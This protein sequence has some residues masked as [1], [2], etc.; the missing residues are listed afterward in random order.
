VDIDIAADARDVWRLVSDI[1]LPARFSS[2]FTGAEWIEGEASE[3]A[4]F[5]GRN[6]HKAIGEWHT[7]CT[8]IACEPERVFA[9]EVQGPD[10]PS[11]EWRFEIE[12]TDDG[13]RLSQWARM[14]PGPSGLTPAILQMPDK[15]E[16]IVER[17]LEEWRTNMTSNLEGIKTLAE[18]K[19][20]T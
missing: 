9:W 4:K 7:E 12:R 17:R 6:A 19:N 1:N 18:Q 3:G 5:R 15:E 11:A 8:V 13:C 2:E 20:S 16:R 14:G 10:G